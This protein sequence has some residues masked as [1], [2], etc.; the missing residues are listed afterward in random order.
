MPRRVLLAFA[1]LLPACGRPEPPASIP[2]V[3]VAPSRNASIPIEVSYPVVD[4]WDDQTR[5]GVTLRLNQRV[6][7]EVLR[8][9][10]LEVKSRERRQYLRTLIFYKLPLYDPAESDEIWATSHFDPTLKINFN[11]SE[12]AQ[13]RETKAMKIDRTGLKYGPWWLDGDQGGRIV[14]IFES[15]GKVKLG[16]CYSG[17]QRSDSDLEEV[18]SPN[19]Q[20]YRRKGGTDEFEVDGRGVLRTYGFEGKFRHA[21]PPLDSTRPA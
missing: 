14:L 20:R 18:P 7:A 5:R 9:I 6:T 4:E 12:P 1:L 13:E 3:G 15:A 10:A 17:G 16:E 19:G 8:E 11:G 2:P 21:A